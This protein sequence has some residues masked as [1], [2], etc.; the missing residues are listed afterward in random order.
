MSKGGK[1]IAGA[2]FFV[3]PVCL[4]AKEY[5]P[6]PAAI[7]TIGGLAE[8]E[9]NDNLFR[10]STNKDS[11]FIT[12]LEPGFR[13][14]TDLKPYE[15]Q[16]RGQ[17]THATHLSH[18][19]NDYIEGDFLARFAYETLNHHRFYWDNRYRYNV[20]EIGGSSNSP[21]FLAA[22]PY[23]HH[24]VQ[25]AVGWEYDDMQWLVGMEMAYR[26]I[27]YD[28]YKRRNG[29]R[30]IQDDADRKN[31]ELIAKL[32]NY[33]ARNQLLYA[34]AVVN[35]RYYD[36]QIDGTAVVGRDSDGYRLLLG[37]Q[38]ESDDKS[39]EMDVAAGILAQDYVNQGMKDPHSLAFRVDAQWKPAERWSVDV[40]GYRDHRETT[41]AAV[42]GYI[43]T[44]MQGSVEY[45]WR[46]DWWLGAIGRYT[47]ND[48]Q[49][50]Q[51][52]NRAERTDYFT[53]IGGYVDY[54]WQAPFA[55][56]L[57][58]E[59]RRRASDDSRLEFDGNLV[60]LGVRAE[61]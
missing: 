20:T 40:R 61:Y 2:M 3:L 49:I 7:M 52:S 50:N 45:Q 25:T 41:V 24:N 57:G 36:Q 51:F 46:E 29:T 55:L 39:F 32:G 47:V 34:E 31:F 43:Q 44:R 53:E 35:H 9:F 1:W 13:V 10:E 4:S 28:N 42:A 12:I 19:E 16:L 37:W 23:P 14:K 8:M 5:A 58:Y 30:S 59:R 60:S 22:E 54:R 48:F 21:D 27:N 33:I 6:E 17:L 26:L 11:D 38:T 18:S 15:M 56:R